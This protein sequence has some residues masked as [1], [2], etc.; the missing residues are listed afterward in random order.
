M[1]IDAPTVTDPAALLDDFSLRYPLPFRI[2]VL[3]GLTVLGFASNLHILSSLGIDTSQVLDIRLDHPATSSSS[4]PPPLVHPTRLYTPIYHL[5]ALALGA[6]TLAWL[7][8]RSLASGLDHR[9]QFDQLK[10]CPA[11][12]AL[13][14]TFVCVS[15]W[16]WACRR[17]RF[18]FLRSLKRIVSPNLFK[19]VPFSD[20]IL[21]D[22]LTSSAKVLGDVWLAGCYL[23]SS[24]GESRIWGVPL[25]VAL[26]YVFRFRQCLSEVVTKQ[27]PTPRRSL[28]NALK[29]ATAFPVIILSAMQTVVGDPFDD[30]KEVGERWIGKTTL[31]GV[32][33]LAVLINSL[34]SFWWDITND[35]GLSLLVPEGW[36]SQ[37]SLQSAYQP[38]PRHAPS[39]MAQ[40]NR[41]ADSLHTRT[42][43][44]LSPLPA[45][46]PARTGRH[47]RAFSTAQSPNVSYP[48]LRPILLLPDPTIYYLAIALDLLLRLTWSLKLSPHLHEMGDLESGVFVMEL[49]EVLRRWGWVYLRIE[50]E[51]VRKGQGDGV[52]WLERGDGERRLRLEED[53]ELESVARKNGTVALAREEEDIGTTTEL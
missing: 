40:T 34:Y 16:N 51:A 3:S 11:V 47:T 18:M 24:K 43:S 30:D 19:P 36:S 27:T 21:A 31:F 44:T 52:T 48:F 32:W 13:A 4:N 22:I 23:A 10:W 17:Q 14:L 7:V 35:W 50:W 33:V 37:G 38:V 8:Y 9:D 41:S 5:G 1:D 20:V 42:R 49:L 12:V 6:T 53:Y 39:S 45:T 28:L 25:M 15:P 26:P 29:Y 46:T 2:L